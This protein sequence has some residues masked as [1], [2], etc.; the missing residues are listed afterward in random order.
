MRGKTNSILINIINQIQF[1]CTIV[2]QK[3]SSNNKI[4]WEKKNGNG[5]GDPLLVNVWQIWLYF[6]AT[7]AALFHKLVQRKMRGCIGNC[8]NCGCKKFVFL[9]ENFF[10]CYKLYILMEHPVRKLFWILM[11]CNFCPS[12]WYFATLK[13]I[14]CLLALKATICFIGGAVGWKTQFKILNSI[15]NTFHNSNQRHFSLP[16]ANKIFM[17]SWFTLLRIENDI[18]KIDVKINYFQLFYVSNNVH[19][20]LLNIIL[21]NSKPMKRISQVKFNFQ[22]KHTTF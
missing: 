21:H 17:V 19:Q 4:Q 12:H 7:L 3:C 20:I 9:T 6:L 1:F 16:I 5:I 15:K 8:G 2:R 22:V 10:F 18:C 14:H 11:W 13:Y